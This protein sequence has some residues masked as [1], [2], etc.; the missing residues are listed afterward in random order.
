MDAYPH[1]ADFDLSLCPACAPLT[2]RISAP[3]VETSPLTTADI[4]RITD[5]V[6]T[7]TAERAA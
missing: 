3:V 2:G 5:R 6:V 4:A 1:P 7:R